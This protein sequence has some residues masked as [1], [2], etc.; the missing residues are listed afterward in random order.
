[1]WRRVGPLLAGE[2]LMC[3]LLDWWNVK[4]TGTVYGRW[5]LACSSQ[6]MELDI[7]IYPKIFHERQIS[8]FLIPHSNERC[9]EE[10]F[11]N[12]EL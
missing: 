12:L 4:G 9:K 8:S 7:I 2:K 3:S 6:R 1:M 11:V 10:T 5:M